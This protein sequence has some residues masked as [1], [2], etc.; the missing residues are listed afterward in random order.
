MFYCHILVTAFHLCLSGDW[1]WSELLVI[2]SLDQPDQPTLQD[3]AGGF[4]KSRLQTNQCFYKETQIQ[5]NTNKKE[6][7]FVPETQ[8]KYKE[9][10]AFSD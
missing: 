10:F 1:Q 4:D 5:W 9:F 2:K 7:N 6:Q 8:I 3:I